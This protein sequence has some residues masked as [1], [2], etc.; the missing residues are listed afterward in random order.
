MRGLFVDMGFS[1]VL[2]TAVGEVGRELFQFITGV[3]W[4]RFVKMP[5][6]QF[7]RRAG[8]VFL[9][10]LLFHA[11]HPERHAIP[12]NVIVL[13]ALRDL[14][15]ECV[16]RGMLLECPKILQKL[17]SESGF[18]VGVRAT[19]R[20]LFF[21]RRGYIVDRWAS[22]AD[23]FQ[24]T[25]LVDGTTGGLQAHRLKVNVDME[26]ATPIA[27]PV[28]SLVSHTGKQLLDFGGAL[29]E[30]EVYDAQHGE[31]VPEEGSVAD[32]L[33]KLGAAA[34]NY[35]CETPP[36]PREIV[37][38]EGTA[39]V[40]E[41]APTSPAMLRRVKKRRRKF[42]ESESASDSGDSLAERVG[43]EFQQRS[44]AE[45]ARLTQQSEMRGQESLARMPVQVRNKLSRQSRLIGLD[46]AKRRKGLSQQGLSQEVSS[47]AKE[48]YASSSVRTE[49]GRGRRSDHETEIRCASS[50]AISVDS[51]K[52]HEVSALVTVPNANVGTR[53]G[54]DGDNL[55]VQ[56]TQDDFNAV[57]MEQTSDEDD[58]LFE[59]VFREVAE[60]VGEAD[61]DAMDESCD[62]SEVGEAKH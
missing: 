21:D 17:A 9:V 16:T 46:A 48:P 37:F 36:E 58:A 43:G 20:N 29:H 34:S 5:K 14:R 15:D 7:G 10:Y 40:V 55:D 54:L 6:N 33:A 57:D 28:A 61:D 11:Q 59:D 56:L 12:V 19:C 30:A 62:D 45:A 13:D 23:T 51:G 8:L 3:C 31:L 32:R 42:A 50:D 44:A 47:T 26:A 60:E 1:S 53:D 18:S 39:S 41:Q 27:A 49:R 24:D 25:Q 2:E 35:Q 4:A 22:G 52:L 38:Q